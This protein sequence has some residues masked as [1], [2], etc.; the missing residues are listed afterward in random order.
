MTAVEI[1]SMFKVVFGTPEGAKC[2]T[3]LEKVFVD[4]PM[5]KKGQTLEETAYRQGEADLIRQII[6]EVQKNGR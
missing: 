3:Y 5:Y 1:T 2:L 4:R 6:K